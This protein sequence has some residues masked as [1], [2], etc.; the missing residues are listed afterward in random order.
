MRRFTMQTKPMENATAWDSIA[1]LRSKNPTTRHHSAQA[2]ASLCGMRGNSVRHFGR[3]PYECWRGAIDGNR[4][5][6]ALLPCA[7]GRVSYPS[8]SIVFMEGQES[9]GIWLVCDGA[10]RLSR[11]SAA[12]KNLTLYIAHAGAALGLSSLIADDPLRMAAE[13]VEACTLAFVEREHLFRLMKDSRTS[14]LIT[15]MLAVELQASYSGIGD[16][17]LARSA[18]G[19]LARVLLSAPSGDVHSHV[20]LAELASCSRETVTR[21]IGLLRRTGLIAYERG[22]LRVLDQAAVE[23]ICE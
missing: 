13:T 7:I 21:L 16:L 15:E 23:A 4:L 14:H 10:V 8:K 9:L 20:Q 5:M 18:K 12:G 11:S 19:R 17:M 22:S 3:V 6:E 2:L 1:R